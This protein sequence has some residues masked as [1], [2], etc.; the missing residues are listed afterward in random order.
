MTTKRDFSAS[1]WKQIINAPQ[2][3]YHAFISGE[4]TNLLQ[5]RSEA[6]ALA[7]FLGGYKSGSSLVKS[8]VADQDEADASV[9]GSYASTMLALKKVGNLLDKKAPGS[10]GDAAR[11]ML[12]DAA[13]AIAE[14]VKETPGLRSKDAV[15]KKESAIIGD[16]E[17]ALQAT[18][19]DARQRRASAARAG[20][21]A[22]SRAKA[23]AAGAAGLSAAEAARRKKEVAD[24]A[25]A[26][27]AEKAADSVSEREAALRKKEVATRAADR[28][29]KKAAEEREERRESAQE[30]AMKRKQEREAKERA[31]KR[32]ESQQKAKADRQKAAADARAAKQAAAEAA[33]V[34][35]YTVASGDSLSVIAQKMYGNGNKW[36]EIFEAN[37]D[38]I[39][40]PNLIRPGMELKIPNL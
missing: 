12:K 24:R 5:K 10:D 14:A 27:R 3:I 35:T 30:A 40:D 16:I 25:A 32:A 20:K 28:R 13:D 23:A 19:A 33:K 6:K 18:A 34:R 11:K 7:T 21:P 17:G 38:V 9:K 22:P 8:M 36:R 15:S 2:L 29:A 4:K 31:A 39:K 37:K 1:E 26:R